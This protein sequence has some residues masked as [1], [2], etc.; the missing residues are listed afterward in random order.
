[1]AHAYNPSYSGGRDQPRQ[2]VHET[3][4]QEKPSQKRFKPQHCKK[5]KKKTKTLDKAC[6]A[7]GT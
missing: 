3:L 5:K 2:R 7:E 6:P 4:F 1:M